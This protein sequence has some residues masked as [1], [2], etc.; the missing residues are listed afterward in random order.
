[1]WQFWCSFLDQFSYTFGNK[2]LASCPWGLVT[3]NGVDLLI[4]MHV[5]HVGRQRKGSVALIMG[6][7][8]ASFALA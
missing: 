8:P 5:T 3:A 7:F 1:M 2:Q 6:L 4:K